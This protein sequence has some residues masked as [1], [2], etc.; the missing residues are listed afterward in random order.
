MASFRQ[1]ES[2]ESFKNC[3]SD[4]SSLSKRVECIDYIVTQSR[5][6]R[7]YLYSRDSN[8]EILINE[9]FLF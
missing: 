9:F 5:T 3:V 7:S 8:F 4:H 6:E 2:I 1:G